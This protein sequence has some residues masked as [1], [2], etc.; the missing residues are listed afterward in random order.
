MG[1]LCRLFR[2]SEPGVGTEGSRGGCPGA[3]LPAGAAPTRSATDHGV[4]ERVQL[5]VGEVSAGEKGSEAVFPMVTRIQ[6]P[7]LPC[8][9]TEASKA[10]YASLGT[11]SK[12]SWHRGAGSRVARRSRR[13]SLVK[14]ARRVML[15]V[16]REFLLIGW[17]P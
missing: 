9:P 17:R 7:V 2:D 6:S 11:L 3:E 12:L 5:R 8:P 1:A 13:P 10:G 15:T 14:S 4:D 16:D